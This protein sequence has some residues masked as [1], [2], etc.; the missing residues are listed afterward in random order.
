MKE[1]GTI[2]HISNKG[3]LIL[4]SKETPAFGLVVFTEDKKRLGKI[5]DVF[6]PTKKPYISIKVPA[7]NS[8]NLENRVGESLYVNS[9]LNK[10]WG[11]RKRRKK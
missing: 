4:R 7:K 11:R 2:S 9:K 1:L 3:R 10:K 6:G 8:K 5:S